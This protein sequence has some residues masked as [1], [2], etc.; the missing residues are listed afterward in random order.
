MHAIFGEKAIYAVPLHSI[1][2]IKLLA[3]KGVIPTKLF[4]YINF[5]FT[6]VNF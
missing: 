4:N 3:H 2:N 1:L 5:C 6:H